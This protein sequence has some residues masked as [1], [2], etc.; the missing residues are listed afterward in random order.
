M[1]C[2]KNVKVQIAIRGVT[3]HAFWA[4]FNTN[5]GEFRHC[6]EFSLPYPS[7]YAESDSDSKKT[8][9]SGRVHCN[10]FFY[11]DQEQLIS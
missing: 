5:Y 10:N 9:T 1:C 7:Y 6:T 4:I 3:T 2:P 8:H 11:P